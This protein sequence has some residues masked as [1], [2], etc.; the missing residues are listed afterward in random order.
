MSLVLG[1][2]E[3]IHWCRVASVCKEWRQCTLDGSLWAAAYRVR[4][5]AHG[6]AEARG[7]GHPGAGDGS[8]GDST[9]TAPLAADAYDAFRRRYLQT[10]KRARRA[11][12]EAAKDGSRSRC[13]RWLCWGLPVDVT[14]RGMTALLAALTHGHWGLA[15]WLLERWGASVRCTC[16]AS[17]DGPLH[18]AAGAGDPQ[19]IKS[20]MLYDAAADID[21]RNRYG[22]TPLVVAVG[23]QPGVG[24]AKQHGDGQRSP[25][26]GVAGAQ[27]IACE[28]GDASWSVLLA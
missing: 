12:V 6:P 26:S 15:D 25:I 13:E 27:G 5:P 8:A 14:H 24:C 1:R 10:S 2:L 11:L 3:W 19:P 4:W 21:A 22:H 9:E 16:E 20:L 23:A 28:D 17:G 18:L 7:E